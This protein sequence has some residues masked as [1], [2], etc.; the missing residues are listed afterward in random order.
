MVLA[1]LLFVA[2]FSVGV[3]FFT[4][5][6]SAQP[7]ES[8]SGSEYGGGAQQQ[9]AQE[10]VDAGEKYAGT[11][12]PLMWT[13]KWL[14]GLI[15]PIILWIAR[16][17]LSLAMFFLTFVIEIGAY[18]D[19]IN[20]PAVQMGW[21]IVR[22]LTNMFFVVVLLIIAFGTI[23]GLDQYE[24]RKMLVKLVMAAVLVNFS[25]IICGVIIDAAQ[26][27]MVTFINGIAATAGG[28][29]INAF[30]ADKIFQFSTGTVKFDKEEIFM[31]SVL[32]ISFSGALMAI[33]AVYA[34]VLLARMIVLWILI[35]TSPFAFVLGLLPQTKSYADQWWKEFGNN[36]VSGP[37]VA[38]V[39]WL[40]F[41]TLGAGDI[42]ERHISKLNSQYDVG[43]R[44]VT[45][46]S[47]ALDTAKTG[48]GEI[49]SW[50]KMANFFIAFG[51]LA[52]GLKFVQQLGVVGGAAFGGAM[53]FG[54]KVASIASGYT[55]GKYAYTEGVKPAA[56]FALMNAPI[57]G[58]NAWRRRGQVIKGIAGI[59]WQN[60]QKKRDLAVSKWEKDNKDKKGGLLKRASRYVGAGLIK[61]QAFK[62]EEVKDIA[63]WRDSIEKQRKE[64]ISTGGF[65]KS[66]KFAGVK[67][68]E[69]ANDAKEMAAKYADEHAA[70]TEAKVALGKSRLLYGS[71]EMP[72][73]DKEYQALEA[74]IIE[75]KG[76]T[77][78]INNDLNARRTVNVLGEIKKQLE[79]QG[80][81][82]PEIKVALENARRLEKRASRLSGWKSQ[83]EKN[84]EGQLRLTAE[85]KERETDPQIKAM[86]EATEQRL[87]LD[88]E[89]ARQAAQPQKDAIKQ[90]AEEL[91][92]R[93]KLSAK[94]A[95]ELK[96]ADNP[97][98]QHK[99]EAAAATL[100]TAIINLDNQI[101]DLNIQAAVYDDEGNSPKARATRA[102][103]LNLEKEE[104]NKLYSNLQYSERMFESERLSTRLYNAGIKADG[105]KSRAALSHSKEDIE[106]A[107]KDAKDL[108]KLQK[109]Q[110][111]LR[112][113]NSST[114]AESS[115]DGLIAALK[116]GK[117]W[118]W[119]RE[120]GVLDDGNRL[121]AELSAALGEYVDGV[122][123]T[124]QQAI[125]KFKSRFSS[126]DAEQAA[127]KNLLASFKG[128][129]Q[130]GDLNR[131]DLLS[132][133][134]NEVTGEVEINWK[135]H[136]DEVA[137]LENQIGYWMGKVK[138]T[139]SIAGMGA[140]MNK[141]GRASGFDTRGI[142]AI[143]TFCTGKD[144]LAI[145]RWNSDFKA[146]WNDAEVT[147]A[148]IGSYEQAIRA[149]AEV[150]KDNNAYK[151]FLASTKGLFAKMRKINSNLTAELEDA[152][153]EMKPKT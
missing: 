33:M 151:A 149:V 105:S 16:L 14:M 143:K 85:R 94:Q 79:K 45:G 65:G 138:E 88:L 56:K 3:N 150:V 36:V 12:D 131:L 91:M 76:I 142:Q 22:D 101:S 35:V 47:Q 87:K 72:G 80:K 108:E 29:L 43:A 113:F 46:S 20:S 23:L 55:L 71:K 109:Q 122:S 103:A 25:L 78:N 9:A 73:G 7:E 107:E 41:A 152:D 96:A 93:S 128:A 8:F 146:S 40:S 133:G 64:L 134:A 110:I 68:G 58:G 119:V 66:G 50:A 106:A 10:K 123:L 104:D 116:G 114:D 82:A 24:W 37:L 5:Q 31:A 90:R 17:F 147:A 6:V 44:N 52:V 125:T 26:V 124:V 62:E 48:I 30:G 145:S 51:M 111:N 81:S 74:R 75:K 132:E 86:M 126:K 77:D 121:R 4:D 141:D 136:P 13:A 67:L 11:G 118:D 57:I 153:N 2:V 117:K 54:K 70:R 84:I 42:N 15:A 148:N 61:T 34:F 27:I 112:A 100:R 39:L 144:A 120:G 98:Y 97:F 60:I 140:R 63:E 127:M 130:S 135:L 69:G 32:A 83:N 92:T 102:K 95:E 49:G 139:D 21:V 129:G 99:K 59:G 137:T 1:I 18:N 28:N 115:R 53:D 38:F 89:A 19:Y